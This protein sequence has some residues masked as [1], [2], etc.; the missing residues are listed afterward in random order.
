MRA[1]EPVLDRREDA[2]RRVVRRQRDGDHVPERRPEI[3]D[4]RH[5]RAPEE[6]L[7]DR[8]RVDDLDAHVQRHLDAQE[9]ED[10]EAEER[11]VAR[12][13]QPVR[14]ARERVGGRVPAHEPEHPC[15]PDHE[16]RSPVEDEDEVR[17]RLRHSQVHERE[18]RGEPEH[19]ED[20]DHLHPRLRERS[21]IDE[22][23]D[24]H[25]EVRRRDHHEHARPPRAEAGEEAP[26]RPQRLLRPDVERALLREHQSQLRGHERAGDQ[27]G[28]EA[29]NPI[30]VRRRAGPL[31]R[32]RVHDEQ[33]DRDEDDRH[34]QG[35]QNPR[36]HSGSDTLRQHHPLVCTGS[37][38]PPP[39]SGIL[40]G[41]LP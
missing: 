11:P 10:D 9:R 30:R 15:E 31:D 26:E 37:H 36:Q 2:G 7:L 1:P 41:L 22:L 23:P 20:D 6:V 8:P 14:R 24:R 38:S 3:G 4:H 33:D 34:V 5:E 32:R 13:G 40:S 17:V 35:V 19:R 12:V 29:E 39:E 21:R 16:D 28:E 27:E 25:D 18:H